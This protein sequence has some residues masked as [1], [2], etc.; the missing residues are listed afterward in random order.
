M[1]GDYAHA[2]KY[3]SVDESSGCAAIMRMLIALR[4]GNKDAVLA[5]A[6]TAI[7]LGYS[8]ADA[9]LARV[10]LSHPSEPELAK[11]V[12]QLESDPVSSRDP[13][14]LYQ[15]AEASAFCGQ[16]DA[17]L[18]ELHQAIQQNYCSYPAMDKDPLFDPIRQRTEFA[19][20]RQAG[21]QCQQNFLSHR[22]QVDAT[23]AAAH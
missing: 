1:A 5:E 7:N 21:M 16:Q 11:A 3:I 13:E 23:L 18:T 15:N 19:E 22:R 9:K 17:A 8:Y 10:C 6:N 4:K 12:A 14:F 2:Q 20:L